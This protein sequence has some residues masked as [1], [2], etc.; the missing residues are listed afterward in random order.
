MFTRAK[1]TRNLVLIFSL[2]AANSC[3]ADGSTDSNQIDSNATIVASES[4][5]ENLPPQAAINSKIDANAQFTA[6]LLSGAKFDSVKVLETQPL[7]LWFWA[8]G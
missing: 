1:F 8:P 6:T 7:A 5:A 4:T 2:L 3:G